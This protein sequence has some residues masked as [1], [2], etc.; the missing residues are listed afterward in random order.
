MKF[1]EIQQTIA[2]QFAAP[3][4]HQ[5]VPLILGAPGAAKTA[6]AMS[7]IPAHVPA[8]NRV[9]LYLATR[10]EVDIMGGLNTTGDFATWVP[11]AEFWKLRKGVGPAA[12]VIDE[13]PQASLAVLCAVCPTLYGGG[14]VGG[15]RAGDLELTDELYIIATGNRPEDKAGANRLPSQLAGRVRRFDM[16]VD[17]DDWVKWALSAGI[18]GDLIAFLRFRPN[19]LSE[20]DA[21]RFSNPTP[22]TWEAV[23]RIPTSLPDHLYLA[24]ATGDVG[25]AAAIEL[26]A[27]RKVSRQLPD[28]AAIEKAPDTTP[29]PTDP[30]TL[31]ALCGALARRCTAATFGAILT[32]VGR[33]EPEFSVLVVK[34]ALALQPKL[35]TTKAFIG[36]ASTHASVVL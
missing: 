12:L 36:W 17:L 13:L 28:L 31:Y 16:D 29:V 23:N 26:L 33:M 19:L 21:N 30:A 5:S 1:S 27:F 3:G 2:T 24:A 8:E 4:G 6:C 18:Q 14:G 10:S 35:S 25:E 32:Y 7:S 20:F 9:L 34:D 22:R 15:R 11:P